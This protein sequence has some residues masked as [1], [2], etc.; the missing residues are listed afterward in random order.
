M[1]ARGR[2]VPF[3]AAW[4]RDEVSAGT[5]GHLPSCAIHHLIDGSYCALAPGLSKNRVVLQLLKMHG[6]LLPPGRRIVAPN[7]AARQN[8]P[9]RLPHCSGLVG[10]EGTLQARPAIGLEQ[11]EQSH[12][13]SL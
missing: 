11:M 8:T 2:N 12:N 6:P 13:G 5:F 4:E 9:D 1:P 7:A 3:F 10:A